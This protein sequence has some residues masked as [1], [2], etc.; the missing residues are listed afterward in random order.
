VTSPHYNQGKQETGTI[1]LRD[2]SGQKVN[3]QATATTNEKETP[4]GNAQIT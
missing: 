2:R 4:E 3:P 1:T